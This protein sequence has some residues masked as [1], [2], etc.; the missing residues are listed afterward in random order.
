[1]LYLTTHATHFIYGVRHGKKDYLVRD[2]K[3]AGAT[4]GYFFITSKGSF[5]CTIPQTRYHI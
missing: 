4:V 2:R 1:M 3:P 5:I